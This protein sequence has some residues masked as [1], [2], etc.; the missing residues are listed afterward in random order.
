MN[1]ILVMN[2]KELISWII[3][4]NH[5]SH[6]IILNFNKTTQKFNKIAKKIDRSAQKLTEKMK[7]TIIILKIKIFNL[8]KTNQ[9]DR[10]PI[11]KAPFLMIKENWTMKETKIMKKEIIV[12]KNSKIIKKKLTITKRRFLIIRENRKIIKKKGSQI[13]FKTS[14]FMS[15]IELKPWIQNVWISIQVTKDQRSN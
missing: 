8:N 2:I 11:N 7:Q 13:S 5:F 12:K 4:K 10:I 9:N 6:K 1:N 14:G 3:G 15:K